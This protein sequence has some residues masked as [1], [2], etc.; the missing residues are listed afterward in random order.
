MKHFFKHY[1]D[2]LHKALAAL[3]FAAVIMAVATGCATKARTLDMMGMWASESGQLAIGSIEVQAI[4]EGVD[5]SLIKYSEDNA[6]LSPTMKLHEISITLTGSNSVHH[7]EKIVDSICDA[8]VAAAPKIAAGNNAS[9][10]TS[11]DK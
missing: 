1:A 5:S 2:G 11:E 10:E 3:L 9:G 8:F 4:P 6:W 7:A